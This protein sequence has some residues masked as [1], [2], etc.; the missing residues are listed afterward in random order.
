MFC[1]L[2][3]KHLE[4]G[5]IRSIKQDQLDRII[6]LDITNKDELGDE[7]ERRLIIEIM[8]RHSNIM[9]IDPKTTGHH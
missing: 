2:L 1:M 7:K 4:G 8:G 9:L 3:R 6:H 5:I